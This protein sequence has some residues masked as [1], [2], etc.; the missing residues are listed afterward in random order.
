MFIYM[1]AIYGAV[2]LIMGVVGNE[3]ELVLLGLAMMFLGNLHRLGRFLV[4]M[5]KRAIDVKT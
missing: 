2:V 4:K 3:P 5:Q 1:A